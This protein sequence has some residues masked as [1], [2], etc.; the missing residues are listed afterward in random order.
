MDSCFPHLA[1][2]N[3]RNAN[4]SRDRINDRCDVITEDIR[5]RRSNSTTL[6]E[7]NDVFQDLN[8]YYVRQIAR[9]SKVH[10]QMRIRRN[11]QESYDRV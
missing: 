3:P 7:K 10:T 2:L 5:T 4:K 8:L 6:P 11:M 9:N 1:I